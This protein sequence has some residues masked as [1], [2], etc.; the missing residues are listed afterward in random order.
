MST[1]TNTLVRAYI[2]LRDA[3]AALKQ[4]FDA[5]DKALKAN[6][7]RLEAAMLQILHT[8]NAESI[9]TEAGT[10]YRQEEITPRGDDWDALYKW[11][12]DNNA[13]EAL[14]RRIKKTFVRE[15]MDVHDG[16]LPPGVS[17][18]REFVAR[19]RRA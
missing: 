17:V 7:D 9:A 15:F 10:F 11:I 1:D 2:K 19:V 5:E 4:T 16:A 6:Q 12:S 14:E 18:Y 3:R 13:F 8:A